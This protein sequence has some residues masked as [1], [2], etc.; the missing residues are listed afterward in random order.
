[1]PSLHGPPAHG[2]CRDHATASLDA[3][4]E[5][6][7]SWQIYNGQCNKGISPLQFHRL[8]PFAARDQKINFAGRDFFK[9]CIFEI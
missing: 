4:S 7:K 3:Q 8:R 2:G 1:M 6:S 5:R 9:V